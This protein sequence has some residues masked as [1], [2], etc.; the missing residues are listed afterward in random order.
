MHI[1]KGVFQLRTLTYRQNLDDYTFFSEG[2]R[3]SRIGIFLQGQDPLTKDPPQIER[4][5][6]LVESDEYTNKDFECFQYDYKR[7]SLALV[8]TV[9]GTEYA[10]DL[11]SIKVKA[12]AIDLGFHLKGDSEEADTVYIKVPFGNSSGTLG[13]SVSPIFESNDFCEVTWQDGVLQSIN[14]YVNGKSRLFIN[15]GSPHGTVDA[16]LSHFTVQET[17]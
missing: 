10:I 9:L 13:F 7:K 1:K 4:L 2:L 3:L 11:F 12:C 17:N 8:M 5:I 14:E 16:E 6:S 15:T